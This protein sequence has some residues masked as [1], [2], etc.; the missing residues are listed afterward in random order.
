MMRRGR[1]ALDKC[2]RTSNARLRLQ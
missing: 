1:I 2:R